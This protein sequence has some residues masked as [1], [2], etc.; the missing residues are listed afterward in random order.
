MDLRIACFMHRICI[1]DRIGDVFVKGNVAINSTG[2]AMR[3]NPKT[4]SL[5]YEDLEVLETI[6]RGSCS[7]VV[8][9]RHRPTGTPIAL[10]IINLFDKSKRDQLIR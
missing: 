3:N 5:L 8:H 6:G 4:F 1:C 10:K 9:A 7:V 2:I